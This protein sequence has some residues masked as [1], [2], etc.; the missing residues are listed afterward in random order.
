V[1]PLN[2]NN[3][4][5]AVMSNKGIDCVNEK[6]L[7]ASILTTLHKQMKSGIVEMTGKDKT[8]SCLWELVS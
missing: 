5:K 3:I 2:T 7:Q 1:G 8:G 4:A 6:A